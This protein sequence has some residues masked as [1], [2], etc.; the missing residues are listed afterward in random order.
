MANDEA[1]G[2]AVNKCQKRENVSSMK[3]A[4]LDAMNAVIVWLPQQQNPA[5]R[6]PECLILIKLLRIKTLAKAG[7]AE[8]VSVAVTGQI[9]LC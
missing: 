3:G 7:V 4:I 1:V 6:S 2:P 9:K 8:A 5:V